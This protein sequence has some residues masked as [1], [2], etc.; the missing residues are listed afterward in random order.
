[1]RQIELIRLVVLENKKNIHKL[2][3]VKS[4]LDWLEWYDARLNL[5][6]FFTSVTCLYRAALDSLAQ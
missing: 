1:M 5:S 2:S 3:Y 4:R 6:L